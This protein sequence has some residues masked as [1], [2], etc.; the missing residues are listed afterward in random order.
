MKPKIHVLI[1][2]I[3]S[4]KSTYCQSAAKAGILSMNDDAIVQLLHGSDYSLYDK[5]LK[6]LYKSIETS[7][8]SLCLCQGKI[9]AI[10]RG[11]NISVASRKRWIAIAHSYDVPCEAI[12]FPKDT[13]EVHAARRAKDGR[14]HDYDYW[15]WVA[16]R[17]NS[18]Y[19]VPSLDEGF[20]KIH[21]ISYEQII[22]GEV[23]DD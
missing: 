11:V 21:A 6:I 22:A 9:V 4:G 15:L 19:N 10:D 20:D 18:S 7:I 8:V 17:H 5:N 16:T 14:G 1:G 23:I 12:V 3:A 13:P 2:M